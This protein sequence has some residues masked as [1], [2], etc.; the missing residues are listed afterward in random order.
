MKGEQP[1][2]ASEVLT[3]MQVP[4][5]GVVVVDPTAKMLPRPLPHRLLFILANTFFEQFYSICPLT[6]KLLVSKWRYG[7]SYVSLFYLDNLALRG[8]GIYV[9]FVIF[10]LF[11]FCVLQMPLSEFCTSKA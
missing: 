8:S 5:P 4:D 11:F 1:V 7:N 2:V 3:E 10:I 9:I 6:I